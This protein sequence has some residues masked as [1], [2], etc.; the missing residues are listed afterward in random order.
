MNLLRYGSKK[1]KSVF[2]MSAISLIDYPSPWPLPK[3]MYA[4][5]SY[6]YTKD[7]SSVVLTFYIFKVIYVFFFYVDNGNHPNWFDGLGNLDTTTGEAKEPSLSSV[8]VGDFIFLV[9]GIVLGKIQST[10]IDNNMFYAF[11]NGFKFKTVAAWKVYFKNMRDRRLELFQIKQPERPLSTSSSSSSTTS[12]MIKEYGLWPIRHIFACDASPYGC[13]F[14]HYGNAYEKSEDEYNVYECERLKWAY[15]RFYWFYF[16]QVVFL[17]TP[18]TVV[19]TLEADHAVRSGTVIYYLLQLIFLTV[20]YFWNKY[21][22]V[23]VLSSLK[24]DIS[25]KIRR[26]FDGDRYGSKEKYEEEKEEND[27]ETDTFYTRFNAV[28]LCWFL[29][30]TF[31]SALVIFKIHLNV[32]LLVI[33][34]WCFSLVIWFVVY[35]SYKVVE[36]FYDVAEKTLVFNSWL[37]AEHQKNGR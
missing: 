16:F 34:A 28:Y 19:Y 25:S 12:M 36:Q 5:S 29:T 15:R 17:G 30:I 14:C 22:H 23:K 8:V 26:T 31:F 13:C 35:T 7:W 33:Y 27:A 11:V 1:E 21:D 10:I 24:K 3:F 32:S 20:F 9:M 2:I 4:Y 6:V 37:I 18:A